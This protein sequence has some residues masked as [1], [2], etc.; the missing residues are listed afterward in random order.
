MSDKNDLLACAICGN[1]VKRRRWS[2]H[3]ERAHGIKR[4]PARKEFRDA[5]M[6]TNPYWLASDD[7]GAMVEYDESLV[8]LPEILKLIYTDRKIPFHYRDYTFKLIK[9]GHLASTTLDWGA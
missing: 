5:E 8:K 7:G 1:Q 4:Y 2:M 3:W 6:P 9:E